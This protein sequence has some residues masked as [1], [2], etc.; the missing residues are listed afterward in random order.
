MRWC[1]CTPGVSEGGEGPMGKGGRAGELF[2]SQ[3]KRARWPPRCL[4]AKFAAGLLA[5]ACPAKKQ[6]APTPSDRPGRR[7]SLCFG[8][9]ARLTIEGAARLKCPQRDQTQGGAGHRALD[10]QVPAPARRR[11]RA[12]RSRGVRGE[13]RAQTGFAWTACMAWVPL[14]HPTCWHA[15]LAWP[16]RMACLHGM[17][18]SPP[19]HLLFAIAAAS[20][21]APSNRD[22]SRSIARTKALLPTLAAPTTKTSRPLRSR[23]ILAVATSMPG[24]G[25]RLS[26]GPGQGPRGVPGQAELLASP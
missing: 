12:G 21:F 9:G 11:R 8:A 2:R 3:L 10:R 14:L 18:P 6:A 26:A 20:K 25:G 16:A 5:K 24:E 7:S 22:I 13:T 17:G 23:Q 4:R 1:R 19:P 15:L